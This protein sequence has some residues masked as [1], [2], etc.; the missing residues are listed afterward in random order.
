MQDVLAYFRQ[1][2]APSPHNKLD[3]AHKLFFPHALLILKS[4]RISAR[5]ER[6]LS[7]AKLFANHTMCAQTSPVHGKHYIARTDIFKSSVS[8]FEAITRKD[9]RQHTNTA[10]HQP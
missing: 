7:A 4:Q 8:D 1:K 3:A 10:A 5:N 2:T 9:G 6:A